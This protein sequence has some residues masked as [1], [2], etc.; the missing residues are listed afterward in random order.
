MDR[1]DSVVIR[2]HREGMSFFLVLY[3]VYCKIKIERGENGRV[4][5]YCNYDMFDS[6]TVAEF[7]SI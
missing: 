3:D 1:S 4:G 6:V 2:P 5:V 7:T